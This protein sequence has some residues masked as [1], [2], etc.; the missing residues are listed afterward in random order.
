MFQQLV[1]NQMHFSEEQLKMQT[2]GLC[3]DLRGLVLSLTNKSCFI[4]FFDWLYPKY[5]PL[6]SQALSRW[7]NCPILTSSV[8]KVR[9]G[10]GI[11][12]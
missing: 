7:A 5:L 1:S 3:C 2:I 10:A 12:S 4:M 11:T 6:L 9:Q 8:L